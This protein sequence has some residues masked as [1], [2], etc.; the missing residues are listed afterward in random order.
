MAMKSIT[1]ILCSAVGIYFVGISQ[2]LRHLATGTSVLLHDVS[3]PPIAGG[4]FA[5]VTKQDSRIVPDWRVHVDCSAFGFAD[6]ITAQRRRNRR[7][8]PYP[9]EDLESFRSRTNT[10]VIPKEEP[11][12]AEWQTALIDNAH[13]KATDASVSPRTEEDEFTGFVYPP[14]VPTSQWASCVD[15][16]QSKSF[17]EQLDLILS[18]LKQTTIV[19]NNNEG[20]IN[21]IAFTIS[22]EAYSKDM[23][24]NVFEMAND[25][26]EF[27]GSLFLIALDHFTLDMACKYGYP[28]AASPALSEIYRQEKVGDSRANSDRGIKYSVENTKFS[29]SLA[30][31]ERDQSFF[32]FEMDVFFVASPLSILRGQTVDIMASSHQEDGRRGNFGV[33]SVIAN[34]A[35]RKHFATCLNISISNPK[36]HDQNLM[37]RRDWPKEALEHSLVSI[38]KLPTHSIVSHQWPRQ[39]ESTIAIH[40]LTDS[41]L[42]DPHGKKMI[43]KE[44]SVWQGLRGPQGAGGYYARL[45]QR[46]RYLFLDN[47]GLLGALSTSPEGYHYDFVVRVIIAFLAA[48]CRRTNRIL[49]LPKLFFDHDFYF[50]WTYL[51]VKSLEDVV[52]GWRET[53]FASNP[54]SWLDVEADV[55]FRSVAR[56]ALYEKGDLLVHISHDNV[57]GHNAGTFEASWDIEDGGGKASDALFSLMTAMP[58]LDAAEALFVNP[59]YLTMPYISYRLS[60]YAAKGELGVAD[61][62]IVKVLESLLWCKDAIEKVSGRLGVAQAKCSDD[63]F[64]LGERLDNWT[65]S[66]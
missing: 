30:L 64:G 60:R 58:E 66:T 21:M 44:L 57:N 55:P 15:V 25:V 32:F 65:N 12:P 27:G 59:A 24:H 22:D 1:V 54:K 43:A 52:P 13:P 41:P 34:E 39:M 37:F 47:P 2:F 8:G 14:K 20:S 36:L 35:T 42:K 50:L 31:T 7:Y 4:T 40:V 46:R 49:V 26:I 28:V 29:A 38:K 5:S 53:N 51:D 3:L 6:C 17:D 19:R 16:A 33:F 11:L 61:G 9:F 56:V 18:T 63:C 45:E 62:E 48:L 10:T 23:I